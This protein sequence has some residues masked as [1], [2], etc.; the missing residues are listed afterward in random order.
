MLTVLL[1]AAFGI[2]GLT[3]NTATLVITAQ[4]LLLPVWIA[5][6]IAIMASFV[7]NFSLS[8][9]VVFRVRAEP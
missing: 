2:A 6:G 8:H 1:A 9:F 3:V 4:I 7:V 5:K